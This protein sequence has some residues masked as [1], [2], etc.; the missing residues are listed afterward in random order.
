MTVIS[1]TQ[2]TDPLFLRR[3]L[4]AGENLTEGTERS[5]TLSGMPN[6]EIEDQQGT[7]KLM[8]PE[9]FFAITIVLG[10]WEAEQVATQARSVRMLRS[11]RDG[12]VGAS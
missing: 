3:L 1:V 12:R 6:S 11:E 8:T 5:I 4:A 9:L 2:P 7:S 10:V